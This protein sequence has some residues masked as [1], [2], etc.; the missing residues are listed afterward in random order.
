MRTTGLD[1]LQ[2]QDGQGRILSSGH[3]RNEFDRLEPELPR[4]LDKEKGPV[5]VR[6]RAP[7]GPFLA[8]AR[9]DSVSIADRRFDLVGGVRVDSAFLHRF[10][11]EPG[12]S[13]V[14]DTTVIPSRQAR[15]PDRPEREAGPS[16]ATTAIPRL[17]ARNDTAPPLPARNDSLIAGIRIP[18]LA[19]SDSTRL[20]PAHLVIAYGNSDLALLR[21]D[22]NQ[23]F[24]A[25]L[26]VVV[27]AT[28]ALAAWLSRRLSEPLATLTHAASTI[29]L[30]GPELAV[31]A[32]RDDEIGTL[33][34]RLGV[35]VHATARQR[36]SS[37]Q[38]RAP[39][40]RRRHGAPGQPRH[41]ERSHP[42][43]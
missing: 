20:T 37:S 5:I 2:L 12:L 7:D 24:V 42:D 41:Q 14:L 6:V 1:M 22:V 38:R 25:A 9:A 39:R 29:E 10:V 18:F 35:D 31:A 40:D 27:V 34:R 19:N 15:N 16:T 21:R 13:V 11:R 32:S 3:F 43:P 17:P 8:L 33:A 26:A 4:T 36:R 30:D 28:L 23:W